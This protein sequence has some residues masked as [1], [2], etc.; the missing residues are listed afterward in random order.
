MKKAKEAKDQAM[1][2]TIKLILKFL[3]F[4]RSEK[5]PFTLVGEVSSY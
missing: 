5:E 2:I 1:T 4:H 3:I